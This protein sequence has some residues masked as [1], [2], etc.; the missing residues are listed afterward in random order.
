MGVILLV[1]LVYLV[2]ALGL[3]QE[4]SLGAATGA[5]QMARAVS[6]AST[7]QAARSRI[8][9]LAVSLLPD[10]GI[11]V[12]ST[13]VDVTCRPAGKPCPRADGVVVVT[14]TTRVTLPLAPPVLSLNRVAAVP[15]EASAAQR[16]S[17]LWGASP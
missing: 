14:V 8:D 2:V 6:T 1:P 9:A 5:R 10:Y 13:R 17:R 12:S 16:M 11:D 3:I 7:A 4:Q 15:V